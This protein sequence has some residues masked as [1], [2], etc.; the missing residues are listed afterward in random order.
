MASPPA[1]L[2]GSGARLGVARILWLAVAAA[3]PVGVVLLL[4]AMALGDDAQVVD[5]RS[6]YFA[7][8]AI[9]EGRSP[10]PDY[11]YPPLTA[12]LA[13]PLALLPL[14]VAEA[15]AMAG[16]ALAVV[17]TLRVLDVRDWR[18]YGIAFL[19]PPV[20]SAIQTGNIT[21]LLGLGAALAWRFRDR[22]VSSAVSVGATLAAKFFLWP[23]VVWQAATRRLGTAALSC[24][25]GAGILALSWAAIGF[26]GIGD[27]VDVV[28]RVQGAVEHDAYTTRV[29]ALDLGATPTVARVVW[30][31]TALLVLGACVVLARRGNDRGAFVLAIAAVLACSPIVWLHYFAL[32]LV[33]VAVAQP[34]LGPVWFVPLAMFLTPGSGSASLFE[35]SLTLAAAAATILLAL[36]GLPSPRRFKPLERS[37]PRS[38]P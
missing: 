7:A 14:G 29:V 37:L 34:R 27:Y 32:L 25:A 11:V 1:P 23:L 22:S 31:S 21:I 10:Y 6:F 38:A 33:A 20:L 36:R 5:F 30:L 4:F 19:W 8:E 12:I 26:A 2:A 17:A 9:L 13:I 15:L 16:L 3:L 24:V 35:R 28:R 18:C